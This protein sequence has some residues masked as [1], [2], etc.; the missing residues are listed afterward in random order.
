MEQA[1]QR[2][3]RLTLYI[4]R[5]HYFYVKFD[6]MYADESVQRNQKCQYN[7]INVEASC[8]FTCK[9]E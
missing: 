7:S 6:E 3:L 4:S 8:R 9:S 5:L 1:I 2:T